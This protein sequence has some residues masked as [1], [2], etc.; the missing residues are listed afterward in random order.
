MKKKFSSMCLKARVF[1]K[2]VVKKTKKVLEI[3][4]SCST[5]ATA[6]KISSFAEKY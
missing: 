2:K 6:K 1:K 5:F 3:I 4:E